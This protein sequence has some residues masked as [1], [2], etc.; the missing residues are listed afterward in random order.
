MYVDRPLV[1]F[2]VVR[3]RVIMP[4]RFR[5]TSIAW[6]TICVAVVLVVVVVVVVV[7]VEVV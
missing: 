2:D 3:E 4:I 7:V 6:I 1:C 5:D